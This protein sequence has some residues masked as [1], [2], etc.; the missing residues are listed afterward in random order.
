MASLLVAARAKGLRVVFDLAGGQSGGFVA[1]AVV[2]FGCVRIAGTSATMPVSG[3]IRFCAGQRCLA[4]FG[5][6]G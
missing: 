2:G 4:S 6:Q 3:F 5:K 1:V